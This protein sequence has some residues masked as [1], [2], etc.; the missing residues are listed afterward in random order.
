[1]EHNLHHKVIRIRNKHL[2]L[3]NNHNRCNL[4]P[5][6]RYHPMLKLLS[7]KYHPMRNNS[8]CKI[9]AQS[10]KRLA[11]LVSFSYCEASGGV[12]MLVIDHNA[13][14]VAVV[15]ASCYLSFC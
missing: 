14:A 4:M 6:S 3:R 8:N 1:M 12:D 5:S 9:K 11:H 10:P 13:S 2:P 15:D 7:N